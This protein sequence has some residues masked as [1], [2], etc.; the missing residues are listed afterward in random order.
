MTVADNPPHPLDLAPLVRCDNCGRYGWHVTER[1]PEP[2]AVPG[3]AEHVAEWIDEQDL[4]GRWFRGTTRA[5]AGARVIV[6]GW[7]EP[8]GATSRIIGVTADVE[9]DAAAARKLAGALLDA[10]DEIDELAAQQG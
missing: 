1:C 9:L 4:A 7:Q 6:N 3:D 5:V 8:G 2:G 10:A